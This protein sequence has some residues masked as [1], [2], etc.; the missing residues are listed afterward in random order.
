MID[1]MVLRFDGKSDF[2]HDISRIT[3]EKYNGNQRR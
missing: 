3:M 1:L 2:T